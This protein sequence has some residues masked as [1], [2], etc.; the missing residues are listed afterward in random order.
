[1]RL[2]TKIDSG[3]HIGNLRKDDHFLVIVCGLYSIGHE[4]KGKRVEDNVIADC[5]HDQRKQR[6]QACH[7]AGIE[8]VMMRKGMQARATL[9]GRGRTACTKNEI[10][11]SDQEDCERNGK[12]V[13]LCLLPET[14]KGEPI[15]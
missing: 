6:R 4:I 15:V 11:K 5:Q 7:H 1:M 9:P 12:A 13:H 2:F 3:N 10:Y 8:P 14:R